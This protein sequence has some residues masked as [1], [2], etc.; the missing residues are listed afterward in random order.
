MIHVLIVDDHVMVRVGLTTILESYADICVVGAVGDRARALEACRRL[1]PDV[2]LMDIMLPDADGIDLA[3]EARLIEPQTQVVL[4]TSYHV[5]ANVRRALDA[6]V[7]GYLLKHVSADQVVEAIRAAARA[8]PTLSPEATLALI[9][10]SRRAGA[11]VDALT[12]REIDVLRWTA[13]GLSNAEIALRLGVSRFT[14][15]NHLSSIFDK[16][17]V[18][19]RTEAT[20]Y[21]IKHGLIQLD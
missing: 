15:K 16:L 6:G 20:T 2:I 9:R 3:R 19:S 5:E 12:E 11:A 21:A 10:S 18:V 8:Q 7:I 13:R 4:M 1:R 17:G 14:V